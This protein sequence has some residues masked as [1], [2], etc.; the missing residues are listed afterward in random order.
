MASPADDDYLGPDDDR[1]ILGAAAVVFG[2]QNA[3]RTAARDL[4]ASPFRADAAARLRYLL[5]TPSDEALRALRRISGDVASVDA[6][7]QTG[8]VRALSVVDG[9]VRS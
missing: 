4:V 6:P 1:D 2:T 9:G 8:G 5:G 3:I 7:A